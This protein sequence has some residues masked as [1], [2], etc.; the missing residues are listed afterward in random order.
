MSSLATT[1]KPFRSKG[2]GTSE[3]EHR[4]KM[5]LLVLGFCHLVYFCVAKY[6]ETTGIAG[7]LYPQGGPVAGDFINLW[8]V[9]KL[10]LSDRIPDIYQVDHF[11]AFQGS[12]TGGANIGLRLWAYPP[13]SLLL[14]WPFGLIGYYAALAVWSMVGLAVLI[15]GARRFGFDRLEIAIILT[16][17]ATILNLYFGQSGSFA[18][19]LMLLALSART[20]RDPVSI[21]AAALLTIKPQVG[22][23]LPLLWMFQRRWRMIAWTALGM[24]AFLALAVVLFGLDPWRDYMGDTLP[25]L[26]ALEREGSGPFMRMIPSTFMA[27]RIVIGDSAPALLIHFGFAA[28]VAAVLVFRL[29]RVEDSDR[30]AAMVLVATALMTPYIHNYDLALL[31][32]SALLVARRWSS[33]EK[34]PLRGELL[35]MIAWALPQLVVLL[36]TIGLP[37]SP[38]LILPLLFMA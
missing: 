16:S 22:F 31:L 33:S 20:G 13:H 35:V 27:M 17:P 29:W 11:M 7:V 32:C 8:S 18:T 24:A 5:G 3:A 19:G 6:G 26:N 9:A 36:N 23:L 14:A 4:F 37:I 15:A 10:I 12:V 25:T 1:L 28:V 38:L 2:S 21:S 34:R 30:R